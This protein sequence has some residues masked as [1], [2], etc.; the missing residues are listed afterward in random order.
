MNNRLEPSFTGTRST[1]E[2]SPVAIACTS[3]LIVPVGTSGIC[4][5]EIRRLHAITRNPANVPHVLML[6]IPPLTRPGE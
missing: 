6:K 3:T 1:G 5:D 4:A 2:L